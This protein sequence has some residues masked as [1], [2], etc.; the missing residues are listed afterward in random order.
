MMRFARKR[1]A[2]RRGVFLV[3]GILDSTSRIEARFTR[4]R[5]YYSVSEQARKHEGKGERTYGILEA[6]HWL[7]TQF[8]LCRRITVDLS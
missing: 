7:I 4:W 8:L 1:A 2:E 6:C 5:G 3:L